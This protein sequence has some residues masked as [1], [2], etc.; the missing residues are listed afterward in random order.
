MNVIMIMAAL[1]KF[2]SQH[3]LD[4]HVQNYFYAEKIESI[5]VYE[6]ALDETY[7]P[8]SVLIMLYYPAIKFHESSSIKLHFSR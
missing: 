1:E 2:G 6:E 7:P 5:F 8:R 4:V 3:C